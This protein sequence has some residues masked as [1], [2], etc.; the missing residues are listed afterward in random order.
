MFI[1][2]VSVIIA[3]HSRPH[4]LPRAVQSAFEAGTDVEV[5][6]IDD[7][8]TDETAEVCKNLKGI[9]YIRV[10]RNQ[11]V[12]GARNLGILAST[13]DFISFHDDDDVRVPGSLDKQLAI[14]A[15][16]RRLVDCVRREYI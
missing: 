8:S 14:S 3:T 7:A 9:K 4:L 11:R 15:E 2:K 1:P 10:E 12:A 13:A 6:V 5:I 16:L